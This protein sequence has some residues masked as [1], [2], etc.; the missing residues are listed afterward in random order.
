MPLN[1]VSLA[2]SPYIARVEKAIRFY[3]KYYVN[4]TATNNLL[5]A[6][7]QGPSLQGGGYGWTD[8]NNPPIPSMSTVEMDNI[9]GFKRFSEFKFVKPDSGGALDVGGMTWTAI[10]GAAGSD[11]LYY[12]VKVDM[13]RFLYVKVELGTSELTTTYRQVGLYSGMIINAADP[14]ATVFAES[15]V[16]KVNKTTYPNDPRTY[17][18]MLEVYQNKPPVTRS[19][20]YSEI[21]TWVLEF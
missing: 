1:T 3:E 16:D 6:T 12:N 21:F 10:T 14:T 8:E 7:A 13:A 17:D 5:M 4:N 15:E 20:Q 11:E 18:G 9:I 19:S 2:I